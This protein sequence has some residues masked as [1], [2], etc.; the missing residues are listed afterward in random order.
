MI[1]DLQTE[2][3]KIAVRGQRTKKRTR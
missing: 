1:S 2:S 3:L